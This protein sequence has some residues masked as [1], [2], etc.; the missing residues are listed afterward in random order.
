[1]WRTLRIAVLLLVLAMVAGRTWLDRVE[2][3]SWK[4]TL[5]VGILPLNGDGSPATERYIAELSPDDF[6]GIE[7]FFQREAHRFGLPLD[8]PIHVELYP[9]GKEL[10]PQLARDTGMVGVAWWSL[11]LRWF[12]A[13][14]ANVPGRTPPR[15]RLFVLYHDPASLPEV[16]DSHGLQKGLMGVVHAFAAKQ[17]AGDNSIVISHELLH[18]LGAT[19]KYD[20]GTGAPLYPTGYAEPDRNPRF[21][22]PDAEIMDGRRALSQTVFEMTPSL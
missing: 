6:T 5:W 1:M 11:K 13:H 21:P 17:M 15:I 7:A 10:P 18:T 22:Q 12:A 16:P 9:E 4:N 20:F 19:D 3:Q 2:T 8:E 14:A